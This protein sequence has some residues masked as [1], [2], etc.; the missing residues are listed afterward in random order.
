MEESITRVNERIKQSAEDTLRGT[1]QGYATV[2][3]RFSSVQLINGVS[4]YALY[5][6]WMLNTDYRG[7]KYTFAMNGQSGKFVGNLPIDKAKIAALFAGVAVGAGAL[8]GAICML[9]GL[10]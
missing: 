8:A 6:V 7:E 1:V 5:P 3:P 2:T 4:K 10:F 9:L